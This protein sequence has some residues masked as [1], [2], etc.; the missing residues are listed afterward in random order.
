MTIER[1][2]GSRGGDGLI[3]FLCDGK[4]CHDTLRAKTSEF[5]EALAELYQNGW[6][7]RNVNNEWLHVCPDCLE[8]EHS[9]LVL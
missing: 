5:Q 1:E 2:T 9:G 7:S 3:V 6:R 4:S 8:A